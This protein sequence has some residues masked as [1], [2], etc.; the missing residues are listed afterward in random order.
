VKAL[1]RKLLRDLGNIKGQA[2]TI[3]LVVAAGIGAFIGQIS[4]YDSLSWSRQSYYDTAKFAHVFADL[5]RAPKSVE[6][7][8]IELSG[9]AEVETTVSYDVTL[10]IPEVAE[11]VIGRMIGLADSG[12]P[13]LNRL[14]LRQGR[15]IEPGR[16][17]EVLVSEAFAKARKLKPGDQL[18]AILNGKRE[19]LHIVGVVLSPEYILATRGGVL[20]DDRGFGVFWMDRDRL[21][22]A[23]NMEGAFNHVALR[24]APDTQERAVIDELDNLL[25][26]Y[27]A[28]GAHGREDQLS[29]KI[30]S[31]EINQQ[32]TMSTVFPTIFLAVAAF[33]LNVVLSRQVATQRGEIAALKAL[34]YTNTAI[35]GHYLKLVLLI[36]LLGIIMGYLLGAF[37]G[38]KMTSLYTTFFHF[39]TLIFRVQPWIPLT[40]AFISLIAALGGALNT[41]RG[42]M[43]LAPAEAMRPPSPTKYRRMLLER[44][45]MEKLLSPQ[46]R[47][48]IRSLER[49]PFRTLLTSF[50]IACS[51]AIIVSGTFWKDAIDFLITVQFTS[52]ERGD[53]QIV[54]TDPVSSRARYEIAH[55]PGVLLTESARAAPVR[56]RAGHLSYLTAISGL[57]ENAELRRLLDA[58][59]RPIVL[60]PDGLLLT[61]RL[62]DKLKLKPGDPLQ[63][64]VLDGNRIKR[65]VIVAGVVNDMFGLSA[66]MDIHA[67][68][69]LLGEGESI[70]SVAIAV[71]PSRINDFNM[72]IKAMPKVATVT[73]KA[74]ALQTFQETSARNILV[75][76]TIVTAFAAA[77][78]IGVVYN[79]VS[80]SLAERAWELASLRV[81]GFTRH[82]VSALLLGELAIELL[83]A[84]PFGLWLGYLLSLLI[85]TLTHTETFYIP[86]IIEPGTYAY[87]ALT[88]LAAGIVSA[89]I[90]R[91]RIDRLDLVGVLKT[92]E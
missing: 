50:A 30:L 2:F 1:D 7:Q 73:Y 41:L 37:L 42:I 60:P 44:L 20:P 29:N 80:I 77:I 57:P 67:L 11:P 14:F 21:A 84:I 70:S 56:L 92:R 61:D 91:H 68:N 64:E 59:Q 87:A 51:V 34:G 65:D 53:A 38:Y 17:N 89:L 19:Q 69:R 81:L 15:L 26:P 31:Q 66:Y 32:K 78:T 6:Q 10:D 25:A 13:R 23:F 12:Q 79:S 9:V 54:F 36:V 27:G 28:L 35:G 47:M 33:L 48:I 72:Q 52:A 4:T 24:L 85:V 22:G 39:P 75:F 88:T 55:L 43:Q 90:V 74:T 62:A 40:A 76:T 46:A 5:K 86:V 58:N 49:R 3:A 8:I 82:E 63:L 18:A 71:E 16:G 45:G 83:L